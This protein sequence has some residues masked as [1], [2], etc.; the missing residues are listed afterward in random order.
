MR[1][2]R[3]SGGL[4]KASLSTS[5]VTEAFHNSDKVRAALSWILYSGDLIVPN[6]SSCV[7]FTALVE[8]KNV[9]GKTLQQSIESEMSG[10]LEDVLV[11]VGKI[12]FYPFAF[13]V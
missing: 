6:F 4:M 11:A 7:C 1:L 2:E 9:S 8:Y 3:K 10:R 12:H 13:A 5:F